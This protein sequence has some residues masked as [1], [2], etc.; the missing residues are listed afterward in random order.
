MLVQCNASNAVGS[1]LEDDIQIDHVG[2][3][4][5]GSIW[6][7]TRAVWIDTLVAILLQVKCN[8]IASVVVGGH[9]SI[10]IGG[11]TD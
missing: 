3:P 1:F 11:W 8:S 6:S 4:K 10:R 5:F 7:E 9:P 2:C